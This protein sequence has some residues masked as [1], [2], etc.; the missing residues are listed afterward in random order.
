MLLGDFEQIKGKDSPRWVTRVEDA[1]KSE[2]FELT[3]AGS[4]DLVEVVFAD[5]SLELR[6]DS[7]A[8]DSWLAEVVKESRSEQRQAAWNLA[9]LEDLDALVKPPPRAA[10]RDASVFVSA[11]PV[12]GE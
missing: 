12:S 11:R 1:A 3:V 5:A 6:I 8:D 4:R 7:A 9:A 2:P 10:Q